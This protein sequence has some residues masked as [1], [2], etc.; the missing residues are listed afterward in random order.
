[1]EVQTTKKDEEE[2]GAP[3]SQTFHTQ[4]AQTTPQGTLPQQVA[5]PAQGAYPTQGTYPTQGVYQAQ[6][7]YPTQ[8][9]Y[10]IQS[11]NVTQTGY[12]A[13][14]TP[15]SQS[16]NAQTAAFAALGVS[17]EQATPTATEI[18]TASPMV[19]ETIVETATAPDVTSS[20]TQ[21]SGQVTEATPPQL[22]T[23]APVEQTHTPTE[24]RCITCL[25]PITD[26]QSWVPCS[27]C[28]QYHHW[29]CSQSQPICR[30]CHQAISSPAS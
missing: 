10:P 5:Q 15:T 2:V 4:T 1:M 17:T 18:H 30:Y 23:P 22:T 12:P 24:F 25:T 16:S 29:A 14:A 8:S 13:Q 19:S 20:Q 6:G 27:S 9:G 21:G 3:N 28:G 26:Q 7:A 11:S